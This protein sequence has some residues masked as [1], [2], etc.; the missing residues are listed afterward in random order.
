VT[1]VINRQGK[2]VYL[3]DG[4]VTGNSL[5]AVLRPMLQGTA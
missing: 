3:F 1:Y 2:V 5:N 4:V